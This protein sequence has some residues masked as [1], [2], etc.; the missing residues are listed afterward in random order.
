MKLRNFVQLA[1]VLTTGPSIWATQ[2]T[3]DFSSPSG[4]LGTSQ[5]YTSN[6]VTITARGYD[7]FNNLTNLFAKN[8]GSD[9]IGVGIASDVD[10]E[11]GTNNFV[12]LDLAN[13]WV[14]NPTT[15]S[16]SIGSVQSSESWK[17]YE[18]N[19][20]GVLGTLLLAGTTDAP[21]SVVLNPIPRSSR[22]LSVQAGAANVLLNSLSAD[23][24]A[25]PEPGSMG[26]L[27]SGLLGIS[28]ILRRTARKRSRNT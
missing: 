10:H 5:S 7:N 11:I 1:L 24:A 3:Y 6:G 17:I 14:L 26:L 18:S 13:L 23:P 15:F 19:S 8:A 4:T 21:S 16:M 28:G 12:Q 22:Y 25:V 27:G 20:A 9:E 2:L